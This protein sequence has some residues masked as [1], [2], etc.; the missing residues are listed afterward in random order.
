MSCLDYFGKDASA[1]REKRL[2]LFDMDGTIYEGQRVFPGTIPLLEYIRQNGGRT[3]FVT[4]NSSRS[5]QDYVARLEGMGIT[6]SE[7]DFFTSSQ[8]TAELLN[9]E[10]PGETVFCVGTDSLVEELRRSGIVVT[11]EYQEAVSVV[12]IGYDTQLRYEKLWDA[13]RLL[14]KDVA[15]L[16]TNPDWVCPTEFGAVPDCG[17]ICKML[18]YATGKWPRFI[19]KP[20]PDMIHAACRLTGIPERDAV[21]LGDRLYTDIAAGNN[22]GVDTIC[23]LTG[24][25]TEAEILEN[26][27]KPRYTFSSVAELLPCLALR[28]G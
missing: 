8:A 15:Y 22:A 24:E 9:R 14:K 2:F 5:V 26:R 4:N 13:C 1:L 19:G 25:A 6:A 21:V 27:T 12:L 3:V 7:A 10:H 16:A 11:T 23:V 28:I 18:E 20:A 17:S